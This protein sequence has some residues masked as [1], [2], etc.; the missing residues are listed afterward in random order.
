MNVYVKSVGEDAVKA[1]QS[2]QL[3]AERALE[4]NTAEAILPN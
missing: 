1:M 4:A 2:L 3:C